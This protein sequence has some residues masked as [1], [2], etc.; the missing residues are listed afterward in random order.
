MN[1]V[2]QGNLLKLAAVF[3]FLQTLI[4]TLAPAV[5]YRTWEVDYRWSQW[6][7]FLLWG[8][9]VLRAHKSITN[10]LPD[11]DPYLFPATA[12]L[13]GWGLLTVW[14][15]DPVASN[16]GQVFGPRQALWLGVSMAVLVIGL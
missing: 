11:A 14:R 2:I 6:V 13:G 5:R 8:I 16:F 7:A 4:I 15:L 1:R 3:L 9:F 12:F 10:R